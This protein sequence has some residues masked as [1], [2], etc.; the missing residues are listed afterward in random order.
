MIPYMRTLI[1]DALETGGYSVVGRLPM[2]KG[3]LILPFELHPDPHHAGQYSAGYD[4]TEYSKNVQEEGPQSKVVIDQVLW[5]R[6]L[7]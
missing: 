4:G 2:V 7:L 6:S 5:G 1:K 3:S